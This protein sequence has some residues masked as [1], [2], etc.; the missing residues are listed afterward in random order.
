M[1]VI[2]PSYEILTPIDRAAILK[3]IE[4]AGRTCYKSED[5]ITEDSAS[6]FVSTIMKSGHHSVIEHP[7]ISVRF[8]CDRGVT[9][10]LVRHRIASY[11]QESTRFCNYSKDRHGGV[12]FIKPCFWQRETPEDRAKWNMWV[13]A[14][15]QAEKT[16]LMMIEAGANPQEARSVLPN[17]LK[18]EIVVSANARE[19]RHIL[20]LRTSNKAHPQIKQIMLPLLQELKGVLPEIYGDI[21]V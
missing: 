3:Q 20:T 2:E 1:K 7:S 9:H 10:E 5:K 16:Y 15:E 12:T 18:T 21:N 17:S 14:M 13:T 11:S 8:V 19:W 6:K 4:L